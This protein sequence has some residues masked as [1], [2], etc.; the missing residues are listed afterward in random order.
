MDD[1]L[2]LT[3]ALRRTSTFGLAIAAACTSALGLAQ[4]ES[5][6][7]GPLKDLEALGAQTLVALSE[8][9]PEPALLAKRRGELLP[10]SDYRT[11][12]ALRGGQTALTGVYDPA[13]DASLVRL[14]ELEQRF[15]APFQLVS[16]YVGF[17]HGRAGE[18]PAKRANA[19]WEAGSVPVLTWEPW[20]TALSRSA[21]ADGRD[22]LH[23][24]ARGHYDAYIDEFARDV[25]SFG[26]PIFLRFAH[27]MNDPSRYPWGPQVGN[28]P[29][30]FIQAF[31]HVRARFELA[32]AKQVLWIYSPSIA[33]PGIDTYYPGAD[34]VDWCASAVLNYGTAARFSQFWS[35]R[36]LLAP[37]YH[38]LA[39][40]G[41]P[42]MLAEVSSTRS[43]GDASAW[44][45]AASASLSDFPSVRA[46]VIFNVAKDATLGDRIVDFGTDHVATATGAGSMLAAFARAERR[47]AWR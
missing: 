22:S 5:A 31:R 24:I 37:R 27:E 40:L 1:R 21:P 47:H 9:T 16:L 3:S 17:S 35:F 33:Y 13:I 15:D 11:L 38:E 28:R 19:I 46:L 39:R 2:N 23:D 12:E 4:W 36:E 18:F 26:Q 20:V 43:G 32:G 34:V 6:A 44:Y 42:V 45:S 7:L 41:H 25:A 10:G 30:H 8:R 29:E 14:R